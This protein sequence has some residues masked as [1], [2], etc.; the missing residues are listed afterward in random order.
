MT[1]QTTKE[2][3]NDPWGKHAWSAWTTRWRDITPKARE[4]T[5][6]YTLFRKCYRCGTEEEA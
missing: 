3:P 2:C 1:E 4:G 6:L 5:P